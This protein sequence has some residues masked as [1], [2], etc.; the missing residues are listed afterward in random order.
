MAPFLKG[1]GDFGPVISA[2]G[3]QGQLPSSAPVPFEHLFHISQAAQLKANQA[4][5]CQESSRVAWLDEQKELDLSD[6]MLIRLF[7]SPFPPWST[8][9][10]FLSWK[11]PGVGE[12]LWT[13]GNCTSGVL[14]VLCTDSWTL[15]ITHLKISAEITLPFHLICALY[16]CT[17]VKPRFYSLPSFPEMLKFLINQKGFLFLKTLQLWIMILAHKW[18]LSFYLNSVILGGYIGKKA[19]MKQWPLGHLQLINFKQSS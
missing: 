7:L 4:G 19:S 15:R 13:C 17:S 9:L 10:I 3:L 8:S 1:R 11:Q 14:H 6:Q 2:L 16:L 5:Q 12:I 18:K